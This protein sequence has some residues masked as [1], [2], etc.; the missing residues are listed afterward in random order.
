MPKASLRPERPAGR[1]SDDSAPRRHPLPHYSGRHRWPHRRERAGVPVRAV[2]W[3]LG[4]SVSPDV[5]TGPGG[6]LASHLATSMFL[7][8]GFLHV[9]GNMLYLWIFGDNVEDRM[10]HGRFLRLLP[11]VRHGGGARADDDATR[12][13]VPMVGASGAMAGVMGAYFVLYP[14]SRI[15][16]CASSSSYSSSRYP[17]SS[18]SGLWFV[19]QFVSGVGSAWP[20]APSNRRRRVLGARRRL[21]RRRHRGVS[22][23][24]SRSV[25]GSSGGTM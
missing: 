16:T 7:H 9:G 10:G 15:V 25:S 6:V 22:C 21:R 5:R 1:F 20:P 17:R 4:R 18:F 24:D 3:R 11:A 19:L 2:A 8:G 23:S 14:Q 13:A 12:L